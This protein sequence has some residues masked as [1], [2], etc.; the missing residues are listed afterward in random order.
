MAKL[1]LQRVINVQ[2]TFSPIAAAARSFGSL[3]LLGASD[4]IDT[5]ERLREYATITEVANDFDT[6]SPEYKAAAIYFGQKPRP[7]QLFVGRWA[8]VAT[9]A[10]LN[11]GV[12]SAVQQ[13]MSVFTAITNGSFKITVD[14]T[15]VTVTGVDL[16]AQT[17]LNG[18]AAVL[19]TALSTATVTWDAVYKRFVVKSNSTGT[20]STLTYATAHTTGTDLAAP[21][22]LT[23]GVA[24][25]PVNGVAPETLLA[26]TQAIADKS[27]A[28][29]GLHVAAAVATDADYLE[30]AGFIESAEPSRIFGVTSGASAVIDG[31]LNT[32][33]ASK[34]KDLNYSRTFVQ[35][36]TS[37]PYA[38]VAM[39]GRAF[40]VNFLGTN[41]AI[42]LKFKTESGVVAEEILTSQAN[43]LKAKNAN[44]FVTYENDSAILQE[45]T[46]AD[47]TFFDE[48][49]GLDWL[50]NYI[51]TALFNLKL[52]SGK[53]PQTNGGSNR[54][55]AVIEDCLEQA[56]RNGLCAAGVWNGEALE[57]PDGF[58]VLNTGDYLD[59]GY[60]VYPNPIDLQDQ[61]ERENRIGPA[62]QIALKLA[63][64]IH[65]DNVLINVNR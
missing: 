12:R 63:G 11:G 43:A 34:L 20:G 22:G 53:V 35:Y 44:V 55:C 2:T 59:K 31:T 60:L 13:Q 33:I 37:T 38:A 18:V 56:V 7:S 61:A 25:A 32:D 14:G 5:S 40:S 48:R 57:A 28:W 15:L 50:Q 58:V 3:L 6:T 36:S 39:F 1:P 24:S 49:H 17:N 30:V 45:G 10:R 64:A 52:S 46:M 54:Q 42:T 23:D 65:F 47:G 41:T 51:Q 16:S 21:L 26:A 29:Y 62:I 8:Q 9:K 4:S 27:N 19:T